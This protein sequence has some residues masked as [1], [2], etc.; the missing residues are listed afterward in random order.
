MAE[1]VDEF[2]KFVHLDDQVVAK[3]EFERAIVER[4]NFLARFR[5]VRPDTG[6]VRFVLDQ[7]KPFYDFN[8]QLEYMT[9][10][11]VDVT[12]QTE[13]Q[14]RYQ[15]I[16]DSAPMGILTYELDADD[17]LVLTGANQAA[18]TILGVKFPTSIGKTIDEVFPKLAK[19]ELPDEY[20]RICREGG[21]YHGDNFEYR[22]ARVSGFYEFDAF[23]TSPG[24]VAVAFIDI[25]ER[26][27]VELRLKKSEQRNRA[28]L[29]NSPVC[30]KILD[31]DF[32]LQYMSQAGIV[33]LK[34]EDV[35]EFYGKPY[36][37][38]FYPESFRSTMTNNLEKTKATGEII[39]QEAPVVDIE[40]DELWFHSTIVPVKNDE[41]RIDYIM[42]VSSD[43]TER[44]KG[45]KQREELMRQLQFTQ[46]AFD[47]AGEAAEWVDF[48]EN[49]I[50]VNDMVCDDLGYTREELMQ[51]N[52]RT[53]R[54]TGVKCG[55]RASNA[56]RGVMCERTARSSRSRSHPSLSPMKARSTSARLS[57][58]SPNSKSP[59]RSCGP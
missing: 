43:I 28:W 4:D 40:G 55:N 33:G 16:I 26:K 22:D 9:G 31:I 50:Y 27:Q 38:T 41:G 45:E 11:V 5:V 19:S 6:A 46:F 57:A 1:R 59:S 25:T 54:N 56:L 7:G 30:T 23:Q 10:V 17:R 14:M 44:K 49:Y 42:V 37:F 15:N 47:N 29:E 3:T 24:N 53:G 35:T 12:E 51:M 48:D 18:D 8:G 39:E 58:T 52:A 34:I 21:V 20:R 13:Y 2:F 36:P 32:N